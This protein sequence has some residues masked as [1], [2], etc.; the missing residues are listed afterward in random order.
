[1]PRRILTSPDFFNLIF[2]GLFLQGAEPK[3]HPTDGRRIRTR[4]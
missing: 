4:R 3:T 1:M 2:A